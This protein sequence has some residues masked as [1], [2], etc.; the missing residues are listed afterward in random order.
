[1]PAW[2]DALDKDARWEAQARFWEAVAERCAKSPAIF[3]YDLMNEPVV[4]GSAGKAKD[5]LGP[6]FGD[7]H[8]VQYITLETKGRERPEVARAWIGR[9]VKAIRSRDSKH[10]ITVG[11][12]PWSLDKPGLTSGFVP[13]KVAGDLDFVAVHIYPEKERLAEDRETLRG[14]AIGKPVIV[15]EMFPLKC[16]AEE[17]GDFISEM[18]GTSSGWIGFYWGKTPD[19]LRRGGTLHDA[20]ILAWLDLFRSKRAMVIPQED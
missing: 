19:E 12:V 6:A 10:L 13:E 5:W 20:I 16:S 3:C 2:Y 17:L 15:E 1:V 4:P 14:F 7:K 11:L 9:L 18:K 8:F